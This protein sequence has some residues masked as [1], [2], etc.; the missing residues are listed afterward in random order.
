MFQFIHGVVRPEPPPIPPQAL[1]QAR[2]M[3]LPYRVVHPE[4]TRGLLQ[5]PVQV[6]VQFSVVVCLVPARG[7]PQS[8]Q[9][10]VVASGQETFPG[11]F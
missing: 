7:L 4:P 5:G 1:T 8:V 9:V 10:Q 3:A 11:H 6:V 2:M